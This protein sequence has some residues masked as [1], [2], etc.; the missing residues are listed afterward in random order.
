MDSDNIFLRTEVHPVVDYLIK[1]NI[2]FQTFDYLYDTSSDYQQVYARISDNLIM[3]A[4]KGKSLIYAVPGH[5]MVAE[6]SVK[7]LLQQGK[8]NGI[9][10]EIIG[11]ESF[12][13]TLFSSLNIDPIDGFLFLNAQNLLRSDLNPD[14][15]TV[16]G[17]IYNRFIASDVKLTLMELYPYDAK[18]KLVSNLGN[19]EKEIIKEVLLHELD[20]NSADF[21]H[22]TTLFVPKTDDEEVK[23]REFSKLKEIVQ[24]LRSPE[25]CPWDRAQ[26]HQSIRKNLIEETYE[27]VETIDLM[28]MNHMVEELGDVL[29]QVLF[30]SQIADED[31]Y[32]D[33]YDVILNLN[34]K[35]IRRHPHVFGDEKAEQADEALQH[36]NQIKEKEREENTNYENESVLN[37]IPKDLPE[38]LKAYKIQKK[39]ASVKFDWTDI[40]DVYEKIY[41]EIN[42]LKNAKTEKQIEEIG[43]LFFT[44]I[45][46]AR[47]LKIDPEAALAKTNRKFIKRFKY[48]EQ[49]LKEKNQTIN[50][51]TLEKME[52]YWNKAKT[53][54]E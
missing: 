48:I 53:E 9:K 12:L 4:K 54:I 29:L 40:E 16:I 43:D 8:D 45:N 7:N 14:K 41:E 26:T 39:A 13:D 21:D 2:K 19:S 34:Q 35:L 6:K 32:F 20:Y 5:P 47:F 3:Q 18:I 31:G 15:N 11:G 10:V 51:T 28:D 23:K 17:Q 46:L 49:K 37:G 25:G 44:V 24:I 38:L 1:N 33:I 22:L 27:L 52:Y 50:D 36:W 30:H 42:E